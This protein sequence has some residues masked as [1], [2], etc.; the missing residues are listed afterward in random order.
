MST[1]WDA[2]E[3]HV[4]TLRE[5]IYLGSSLRYLQDCEA[6]WRVHG[7]AYLMGNLEAVLMSVERFGLPRARAVAGDLQRFR[8]RMRGASPDYRVS[9][10]EATALRRFASQVK[11]AMREDIEGRLAVTLPAP[12]GEAVHWLADLDAALGSVGPLISPG[13]RRELEEGT[14]ALAMGLP[15][16]AAAMLL[17][18]AG[19]A[20]AEFYQSWT[21]APPPAGLAWWQLVDELRMRPPPPPEDLLRALEYLASEAG[22]VFTPDRPRYDHPRVV[23]LLELV[24]GAVARMEEAGQDA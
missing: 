9:K 8:E 13:V 12:A 20:L 17:R 18:A 7:D 22:G 10:D 15:A 21:G 19:V 4:R 6:G 16:A 1:P 5:W 24:R 23:E 3:Q 11:A 14:R 2:P